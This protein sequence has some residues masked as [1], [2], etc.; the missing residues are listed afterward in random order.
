MEKNRYLTLDGLRGVAAICVVLHHTDGFHRVGSLAPHGYLAVDFFLMLS[1]FVIALTYQGRLSRGFSIGSF[2]KAR[3]ARLYPTIAVGIALGALKLAL[4]AT[5]G[6]NTSEPITSIITASVLNMSLLPYISTAHFWKEFF[7]TNPPMWS[8]VAEICVNVFW[9]GLVLI[10]APRVAILAIGALAGAVF[11]YSIFENGVIPPLHYGLYGLVARVIFGFLLGV[12]L[13]E[14]RTRISCSPALI[15]FLP[16]ILGMALAVTI[17]L[18]WAS[19]AW[20]IVAIF[21]IL[22]IIVV[23]GIAAGTSKEGAIRKF[24]GDLSFPLY[25]VHYPIFLLFSGLQHRFFSDQNIW[26]FVCA[27]FFASV[28]VAIALQTIVTGSGRPR[29]VSATR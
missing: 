8:I 23:L 10:R 7:P 15:R 12:V 11:V 6:H 1:G 3:F 4:D 14:I 22:P 27:A 5:V 29:L 21:M 17:G 19:V 26:L 25:A 16:V 2:V 28:A 9:A 24:L 20:D 13:Y 18:P